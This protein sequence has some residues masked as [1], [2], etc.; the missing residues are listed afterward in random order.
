MKK[1]LIIILSLLIIIGAMVQGCK[2]SSSNTTEPTPIPAT[3]T[4]TPIVWNST[5]LIDSMDNIAGGGAGAD[6]ANDIPAAQGGPGYWYTYDDIKDVLKPP[7]GN[8][9]TDNASYVWP[10]SA[11]RWTIVLGQPTP[12]PTFVMSAPG[13]D[14][15]GYCA[16][17][18][19]FVT[20]AFK[21]G[22][23][24]MGVNFLGV[25]ADQSKKPVDISGMTGVRFYQKGDGK[26][27]R[28]K[29]PSQNPLFV[30]GESDDHY[31]KKFTSTG[32]WTQIDIPLNTFTQEGWG[33]NVPLADA[34]KYIDSIQIQTVGQPLTSFD[35]SVDNVEIYK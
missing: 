12:E 10:M 16:R 2:K 4:P 20:T 15:T 32:S 33:S 24:G 13:Y 35:L 9:N 29:L 28:V 8:G 1:G 14:G 18:T 6:N 26:E 30:R 17:M 11:N 34:L 3:N 31:G 5:K 23:A 22:F 25:N 21:Y 7:D 19:G 27:Y